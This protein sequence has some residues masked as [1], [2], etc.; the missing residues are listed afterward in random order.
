MRVHL[1]GADELFVH[2]FSATNSEKVDTWTK[3]FRELVEDA[4]KAQK[5]LEIIVIR[6]NSVEM[7]RQSSPDYIS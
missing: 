7:N 5:D 2:N 6:G 3:A 4:I 1:V